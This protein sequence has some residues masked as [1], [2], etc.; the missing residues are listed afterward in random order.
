MSM[1]MLSCVFL[2][3]LPANGIACEQSLVTSC[4][5][6][7]DPVWKNKILRVGPSGTVSRLAWTGNCFENRLACPFRSTACAVAPSPILQSRTSTK[8][9]IPETAH[10]IVS[11]SVFIS[12]IATSAAKALRMFQDVIV[13]YCLL[14]D[15]LMSQS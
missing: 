1:Y 7:W 15:A 9:T 11:G 13:I 14:S 5:S 10:T 12:R 6:K 2:F 8:C 3:G 4:V